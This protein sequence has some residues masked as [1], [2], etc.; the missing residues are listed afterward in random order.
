[1]IR[2]R[3]F[4]FRRNKLRQKIQ[5]LCHLRNQLKDLHATIFPHDSYK[6]TPGNQLLD[7]QLQAYF[8]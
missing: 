4:V 6:N 2:A 7:K 5:V 3:C 8:V 1:M